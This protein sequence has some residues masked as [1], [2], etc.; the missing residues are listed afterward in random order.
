MLSTK[1]KEPRE[2][3]SQLSAAILRN[4]ASLE[5]DTVLQEVVDSARALT[6]ARYG[7]ITTVDKNGAVQDFVSAGFTDEEH[8]QFEQWPDG[9]GLFGHLPGADGIELIWAV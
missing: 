2:R 9:P 6:G 8:R 5:V 1:I 4:S 3:F 7:I